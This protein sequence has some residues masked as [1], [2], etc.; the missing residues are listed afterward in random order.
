MRDF[1][2][3]QVT[4]LPLASFPSH[5]SPNTPRNNLLTMATASTMYSSVPR[6]LF[7]LYPGDYLNQDYQTPINDNSGIESGESLYPQSDNGVQG[8]TFA[9]PLPFQK[10]NGLSYNQPQVALPPTFPN[11]SVTYD[12]GMAP[13]F[14]NNGVTY[15]GGFLPTP[16]FQPYMALPCLQTR[17]PSFM[18]TPS[19]PSTSSSTSLRQPLVPSPAPLVHKQVQ[20]AHP[21]SKEKGKSISRNAAQSAKQELLGQTKRKKRGPNRRPGGTSFPELLVRSSRLG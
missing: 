19:L 12:G 16:T 6:P 1:L 9:Y 17:T 8:P 2:A 14:L 15:N 4:Q 10:P 7:D 3:F 13:G 20:K 18:T 11:N 21:K 5:S